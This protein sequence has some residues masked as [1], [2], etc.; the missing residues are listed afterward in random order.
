M[1]QLH[2]DGN[3]LVVRLGIVD[4]MLSMRSTMRF[5]LTAVQRIYVDPVVAD[6]PRGIKAPGTYVPGVLTKGTFHFDG[7]KTY[8]NVRRGT[9]AIVVELYAQKLDRLVIEQANP[10]TIIQEIISARD[11]LK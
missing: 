8:W 4:V 11:A 1:A 10:A 2:V 5:P 3:D 7:V 9:D 6:E